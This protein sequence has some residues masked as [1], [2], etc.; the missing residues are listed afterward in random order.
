MLF[1]S[2]GE[3]VYCGENCSG[4]GGVCNLVMRNSLYASSTL[5][6]A[7]SNELGVGCDDAN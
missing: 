1:I 3:L 2:L 5:Q 4:K 6:F 7:W